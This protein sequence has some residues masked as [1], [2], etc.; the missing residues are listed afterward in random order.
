[1]ETV[2]QSMKRWAA[3]FFTIW[4]GQA[5][6]LLGSAL[7]QFGLVWWL[8]QTTGSATVLA[9]ATAFWL[10]VG[11]VFFAGLMNPIANGPLMAI[12]QARVE[13]EMPGT[14]RVERSAR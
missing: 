8:T 12:V 10:A 2:E 13:P 6:S 14:S 9:T 11:A 5:A 4:A 3:P 1:M 7:V